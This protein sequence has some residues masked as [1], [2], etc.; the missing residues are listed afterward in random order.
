LSD[1]VRFSVRSVAQSQK[2]LLTTLAAVTCAS[3]YLGYAAHIEREGFSLPPSTRDTIIRMAVMPIERRVE[4]RT[5]LTPEE[6]EE[7]RAEMRTQMESQWLWSMEETLGH[8]E[9]FIPIIVAAAL[10]MS[11]ISIVSLLSWLPILA[12]KV[13]FS[14]L[15]ALRM[16]RVVTETR[17][18]E[19]L[20]LD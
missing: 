8:Y 1:R 18:I 16:T 4:G 15:T 6:K 12:L 13:V 10:F 9:Q 2:I 14:L 19:R 5:D 11:L 3:L 20:T 17:E 7:V